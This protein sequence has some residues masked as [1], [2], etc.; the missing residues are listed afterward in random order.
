MHQSPGSDVRPT[1][2]LKTYPFIA[3]GTLATNLTSL[4]LSYICKMGVLED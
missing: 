4:S 1:L 3:C 2:A